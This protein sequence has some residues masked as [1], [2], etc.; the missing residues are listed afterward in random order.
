VAGTCQR[1]VL[2]GHLKG[3]LLVLNT[4]PLPVRPGISTTNKKQGPGCRSMTYCKG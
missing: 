4:C 2:I 3:M 1:L